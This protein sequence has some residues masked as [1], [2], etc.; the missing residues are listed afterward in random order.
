MS[1]NTIVGAVIA[2]IHWGAMDAKNLYEE[3]DNGFLKYL[4]SSKILDFVVI[5]GD[6]FD[7]KLHLSSDHV[8]YSFIFL[9]K[10]I[11]I[12]IKKNTKLRIIKG[13][14]SH[15]HGQLSVLQSFSN[16]GADFKIIE[17]VSDEEL[18][19][20]FN[21]LYIPEEYITDKDEYYKD[22]FTKEYDMI[23][24]HGMFSEVAFVAKCQQ[25]EITHQ[26]APIFKSEEILKICKSLTFFGHIHKPQC[27]KDRIYYVGSYSRWV[28]G[29]EEPKGFMMCAYTPDTGNYDVE[30]IENKMAPLYNTM[31]IDYRS[32]FYK[33]DPDMQMQYIVRMVNN[34]NVERVRIIFN[35]PEDYPDP[36]LLT[37]LI[38]DVFSKYR[39]VKVVI[40]NNS[41]ESKQKQEM[42]LKIKMLLTKYEYIFDKSIAPEEKLSRYIKMKYN[43]DINIS[44]MRNYLYQKINF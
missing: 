22:F 35:I 5:A 17:T 15:D 41:K 13:T 18:F 12:C 36:R 42:E 23:F 14:S 27:I 21:V 20:N 9:K 19:P 30:F 34:L 31:I 40:N 8:K 38:T 25:S 3:L 37:N 43:K 16:L 44:N 10:L 29:E 11:D 32:S 39:H 2:D 4:K 24:G 1:N 6:L 33:D 7:T 28:Y 26:K